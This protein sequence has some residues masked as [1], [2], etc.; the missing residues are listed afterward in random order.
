M[1]V[2]ALVRE[3]N[4]IGVRPADPN[5]KLTLDQVRNV[6]GHAYPDMMTAA[7]EGPEEVG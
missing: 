3:F 7:I 2:D 4:C 1:K 6:Y 5:P